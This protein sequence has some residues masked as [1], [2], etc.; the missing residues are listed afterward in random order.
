MAHPPQA[1]TDASVSRSFITEPGIG[2]R[3]LSGGYSR[4]S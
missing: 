1:R 3:F 2:Y 4:S